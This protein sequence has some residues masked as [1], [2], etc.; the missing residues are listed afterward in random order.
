MTNFLLNGKL[1]LCACVVLVCGCKFGDFNG[2]PKTKRQKQAEAKFSAGIFL[3]HKMPGTKQ[4]IFVQIRNLTCPQFMETMERAMYSS[5]KQNRLNIVNDPINAELLLQANIVQCDISKAAEVQLALDKGYGVSVNKGHGVEN[6]TAKEDSSIYSIIADLQI[7]ERVMEVK[8]Q[9]KA[10]KN[11]ATIKPWRQYQTRLAITKK[12]IKGKD[13]KVV[14]GWLLEE[15]AT[16]VAN[17]FTNN[18]Q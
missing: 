15:L 18:E 1:L 8:M 10:A 9:P 12:L 2:L 13:F 14:S 4:R 17:I 11:A 16:S 5:L 7:S 6:N 3:N